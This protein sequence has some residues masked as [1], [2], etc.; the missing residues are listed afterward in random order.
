MNDV[1]D[2][3]DGL[4]SSSIL[5]TTS[6]NNVPDICVYMLTNSC[7]S[8][9][10]RG[11]TTNLKRRLRQHRG[12]LVGGARYTKKFDKCR[13]LAYISGFSD[14]RTAMS[15]EWHTKR[16]R[17]RQYDP[18]TRLHTFVAPVL[19]TKFARVRPNLTLHLSSSI[20]N[21][22]RALIV[23]TFDICCSHSLP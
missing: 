5:T 21:N 11:Y 22:D 20:P 23:S 4:S 8:L 16:R 7:G 18:V 1:P 9:S 19:L 17:S 13:L 2:F 15:F 10:Y 6:S 3:D 14:K 12:E